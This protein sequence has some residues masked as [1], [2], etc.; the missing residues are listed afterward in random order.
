MRLRFL[1]LALGVALGLGCQRD[2]SSVGTVQAVLM[3]KFRSPIKRH[4]RSDPVVLLNL[5]GDA[6]SLLL[7]TQENGCGFSAWSANGQSG[8]IGVE[9]RTSEAFDLAHP[10]TWTSRGTGLRTGCSG[11]QLASAEAYFAFVDLHL[12]VNSTGVE[13]T[14]VRV[15]T[16]ESGGAKFGDLKVK[17]ADG[18]FKWVD[19]SAGDALVATRP[20]AP[21]TYVMN[22]P[23]GPLTVPYFDN[24]GSRKMVMTKLPLALATASVGQDVSPLTR[25]VVFDVD[26]SPTLVTVGDKSSPGKVA[27]TLSVPFLTD[28]QAHGAQ[29]QVTV[30]P[31]TVD[32]VNGPLDPAPGDGNGQIVPTRDD[33]GVPDGGFP[34]GGV[35]DAGP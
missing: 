31:L 19:T 2:T 18:S 8:P 20:A 15:Y 25:K 3:G 35:R 9:G 30:T 34:D 23:T 32:E 14:V 24:N 22:G 27:R 26:L 7:L 6:D 12:A 33:G 29:V 11:G 5:T 1:V 13:D 10:R 28:I 4:V 16:S 21:A 17:D